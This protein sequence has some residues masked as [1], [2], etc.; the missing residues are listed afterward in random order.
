M[1]RSLLFRLGLLPLHFLLWGWRDSNRYYSHAGCEAAGYSFTLY[2]SLSL[3]Y[4]EFSSG[5]SAGLPRDFSFLRQKDFG[6]KSAFRIP[7]SHFPAPSFQPEIRDLPEEQLSEEELDR[8]ERGD[9]SGGI[10]MPYWLVVLTYA[11]VWLGGS[12][13]LSMRLRTRAPTV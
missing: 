9:S 10:L 3:F 8:L 2:H 7:G 5:S 4:V 11:A 12:K 1:H 6:G 13:W